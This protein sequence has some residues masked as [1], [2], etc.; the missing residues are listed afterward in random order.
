MYAI[1]TGNSVGELTWVATEEAR[2]AAVEVA[3]E[4]MLRD[5][6]TVMVME[7]FGFRQELGE[8]RGMKVTE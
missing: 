6:E 3:N 2:D 5:E 1:F 8:D 4:H 7:V